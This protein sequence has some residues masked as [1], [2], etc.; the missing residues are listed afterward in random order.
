[1]ADLRAW[2]RTAST[3]RDLTLLA[4]VV[5]LLFVLTGNH[6]PLGSA[7]RYAEACREMVETGRWGTPL[8]GYVP[9]FEKPIFGYWLGAVCQWLFGQGNYAVALPGGLAALV[10]VWATYGLGVRLRDRTTGLLGALVLLGGGYFLGMATIFTTDPILAACLAVCWWTWWCWEAGHA[11]GNGRGSGWIWAFWFALALGFLTKGPV[12][13]ALAGA[14][15]AGYAWLSGGFRNIWI[16]LWRMHPLR[17]TA[18]LIAV[19]LPWSWAIYREDPRFLSFFYIRFNLEALYTNKVNHPE[20][21]WFYGPLLPLYLAPCVLLGLPALIAA[22]GRV[23]GP[24]LRRVRAWG[25]NAAPTPPADRGW[26]FLVAIVI[27]PLVFLSVSASKLPTYPLPLLPAFALLV[28]DR[29]RWWQAA[30][31]PAGRVRLSAWLRWPL[32]V[33]AGILVLACVVAP[34]VADVPPQEVDWGLAAWILPLVL[35]TLVVG[36]GLAAWVTWRGRILAGQFT[37]MATM[38]LVMAVGFTVL[39]SL[40][41]DTDG[42]RLAAIIARDGSST[43]RVILQ[44]EAMHRYEFDLVLGRRMELLDDARERGMGHFAEVVPPPTPFPEDTYTVSGAT[45][46]ANRWLTTEAALAADWSKPQRL[47]LL[48][49]EDTVERLRSAGV[50]VQ[51]IDRAR[52]IFLVSNRR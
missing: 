9:Y 21:A 46:P 48:C 27:F 41:P 49:G 29:W 2:L 45:L 50:R 42:R 31:Q 47:W 4:G 36:A 30:K 14:A 13:V 10:S 1:M 39:G 52:L 33:Q 7:T 18:V 51:V 25:W 35:A 43:D 20:A 22:C 3:G 8:L 26:L 17:G 11:D 28:A 6:P 44:Q 40:V 34:L 15:I 16:T 23:L 38:V 32:V 12:A 37:L 24:A 5:A 19:N